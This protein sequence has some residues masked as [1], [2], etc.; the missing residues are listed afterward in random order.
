[1]QPKE[2]EMDDLMK[3]AAPPHL[4]AEWLQGAPQRLILDASGT[5]LVTYDPA[6]RTGAVYRIEAGLWMLHGPV[7]LGEFL[8]GLASFK[9]Q[10]PD[11]HDFQL[12]LDAVSQTDVVP[13]ATRQ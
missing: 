4:R 2:I 3:V 9:I 12:W 5:M 10:L 6:T 11:V 8:G 13:G 1:V 7:A